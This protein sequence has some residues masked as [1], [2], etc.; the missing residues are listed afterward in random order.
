MKTN[1]CPVSKSSVSRVVTN[2]MMLVSSEGIQVPTNTSLMAAISP[3]LTNILRYNH[4][5]YEEETKLLIKDYS[6]E[7]VEAFLEL[8]NNGDVCLTGHQIEDVRS[9]ISALGINMDF[10]TV[11]PTEDEAMTEYLARYSLNGESSTAESLPDEEGSSLSKEVD[12]SVTNYGI[13]SFS[14]NIHRFLFQ[15]SE[16]KSEVSI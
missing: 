16:R 8:S 3:V 7:T 13:F 9:L 14:N 4:D 1:A 10:F 6:T 5:H 15:T 12:R 2:D 11:S